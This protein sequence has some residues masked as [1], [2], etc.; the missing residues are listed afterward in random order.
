[1]RSAGGRVIVCKAGFSRRASIGYGRVGDSISE[2]SWHQLPLILIHLSVRYYSSDCKP[3]RWK[4]R[5]RTRLYCIFQLCQPVV[6]HRISVVERPITVVQVTMTVGQPL[7][8]PIGMRVWIN[9]RGQ[10]L[11]LCSHGHAPYYFILDQDVSVVTDAHE[12]F[13]NGLQSSPAGT[14]STTGPRRGK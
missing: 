8:R 6:P 5:L 4:H 9:D 10:V 13:A 1:M 2:H 12:Y 14:I 7:Y 11:G 3:G